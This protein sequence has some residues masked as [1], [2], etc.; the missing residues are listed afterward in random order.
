M[1]GA[2]VTSPC[3]VDATSTWTCGLRR[4]GGYQ[5]QAIWNATSASSYTPPSKFLRYSDLAGHIL[6]ITGG[7][8]MIGAKPILLETSARQQQAMALVASASDA[9][10]SR[11]I[12]CADLGIPGPITRND[13]H[14]E[15]SA[16]CKSVASVPPALRH[17]FAAIRK[18][19]DDLRQFAGRP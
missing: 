11:H 17:G 4:P 6:P 14:L 7:S 16:T 19:R 8:I 9:T 12:R 2:M 5:A 10:K 15:L 13:G 18:S 1:V 3:S